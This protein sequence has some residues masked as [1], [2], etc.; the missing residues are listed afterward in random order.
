MEDNK[1]E[2]YEVAKRVINRM[3]RKVMKEDSKLIDEEDIRVQTE[4]RLTLK[5]TDKVKTS[6]SL[7][8]E[9][10][11]AIVYTMQVF[12]KAFHEVYHLYLEE[13]QEEN[14]VETQKETDEQIPEKKEEKDL[15]I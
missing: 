1:L 4:L 5:L 2:L 12:N 9:A 15:E 7:S 6:K 3:M 8:D 10:E 14:Q 13:L 11:K